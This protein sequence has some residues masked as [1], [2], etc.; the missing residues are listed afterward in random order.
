MFPL[1]VRSIDQRGRWKTARRTESRIVALGSGESHQWC[2]VSSESS[3]IQI[4][5][6]SNHFCKSASQECV[7]SPTFLWQ[8]HEFHV[9]IFTI[10]HIFLKKK[11]KH[12]YR[13][14]VCVC[15]YI[16]Q[17]PT[18]GVQTAIILNSWARREEKEKLVSLSHR[19]EL[20]MWSI[21]IRLS[22]TLRFS[23]GFLF[24]SNDPSGMCR[25]CTAS[26]T[27]G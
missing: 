17:A 16:F 3:S 25:A 8:D 6:D 9:C 4:G 21:F 12:S 27:A 22:S 24:T 18:I 19:C 15:V 7:A 13:V 20:R 14:C 1:N 2:N 5:R 11:Q 26:L 10:I 23:L